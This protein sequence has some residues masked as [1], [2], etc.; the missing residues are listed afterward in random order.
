LEGL[1]INTMN[2]INELIVNAAGQY[3]G[4][5]EIPGNKGWEDEKFQEKMESIGWMYGWAWCSVFFELIWS[6]AYYKA[7]H[8]T[9]VSLLG[10]LC[11]A[12]VM[13]TYY[14]FIKDDL[15][16]V[17]RTPVVGSGIVYQRYKNWKG[18][19]FGHI[20]IVKS[21][22]GGAVTTI[23]GNTNAE[24][25]REGEEVAEKHRLLNF[26]KKENG[27]VLRGFIHPMNVEIL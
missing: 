7:G 2:T 26:N 19:N 12:S 18:T 6:E 20:G 11:S 10:K 21:L 5:A 16:Q 27:L 15:F 24:G 23:E 4:Q 3:I 1:K 14:N 13:R 22:E 8:S 9:I 17:S 25:H